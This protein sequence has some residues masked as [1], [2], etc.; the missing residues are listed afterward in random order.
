MVITKN[1][2]G[3]KTLDVWECNDGELLSFDGLGRPQCVTL[4][5]G[6]LTIP[7][8]SVTGKPTT[9]SGYGITDAVSN[10]GGTPSV[11]SGLDASRPT[12]GTAGRVYISTDANKIYRDNGTTWVVI[13]TTNAGDLSAGTLPTGRLPA[14][15][16]DVTSSA[17]SNTMTIANNAV[18]SAK[19]ADGAIVDADISASANIAD[20]KLATISTAGKVSGNAITSG[21][22]GGSTAINTS[23]AI[24]TSGL[25]RNSTTFAN[26]GTSIN[27]SNGNLQTTTASCGSFTFSNMEDGGTYTLIVQGSTSATCTF[28]QSG[29]T[30]RF[31]PANGPTIAGTQ[32][33]YTFLRAGS[34]VYVSWVTGYQ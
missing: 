16:G 29:L 2:S 13:G 5:S 6:D 22:I 3:Q 12:A 17:G 9:L 7:W 33:V 32:T 4:S 26:T 31:V 21:T 8:S 27:W 18:T 28:T 1:Q 25:F 14:F 24:V 23:G 10:A 15:A 19:I 11:Q 30:F 34:N 20:T